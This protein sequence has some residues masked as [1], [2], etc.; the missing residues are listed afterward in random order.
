MEALDL[1]GDEAGFALDAHL[2]A[3]RFAIEHGIRRTAQAGEAAGAD[4]VRQTLLHL[5]RTELDTMF[6]ALRTQRRWNI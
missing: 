3:F 5:N 2:P 4:S 6:A 1:A